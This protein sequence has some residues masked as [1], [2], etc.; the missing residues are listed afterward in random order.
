MEKE[1]KTEAKVDFL[2]GGS[3]LTMMMVMVVMLM[4]DEVYP[5]KLKERGKSLVK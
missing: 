3:I 2:D 1:E 4:S 5:G